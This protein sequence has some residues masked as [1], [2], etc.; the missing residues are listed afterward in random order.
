MVGRRFQRMKAG[1]V[2]AITLAC[3]VVACIGIVPARIAGGS[4][5]RFALIRSGENTWR[6]P[7]DADRAIEI[8]GLVGITKLVIED[9]TIR[10]VESPGEQRIIMKMGAVGTPGQWLLSVPNGVLV[11]IEGAQSA[12]DE[13][14]VDDVAM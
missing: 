1:D 12:T 8:P 9:G 13:S 11:T 2:V 10:A 6:Y 14:E 7:L 3:V 4:G 5:A